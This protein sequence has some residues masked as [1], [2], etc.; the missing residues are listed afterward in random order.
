MKRV[1]FALSV[2]LIVSCNSLVAA[3]T[4]V[5]GGQ[6]SV[7]LDFDTLKNAASLD[8]SSVSAE[9]ASP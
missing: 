3:Q 8:L 2:V 1:V 6:K 4:N 7:A 9:V 5:I